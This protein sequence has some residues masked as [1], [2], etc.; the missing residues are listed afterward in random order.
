MTLPIVLGLSLPHWIIFILQDR[1]LPNVDFAAIMEFPPSSKTPMAISQTPN[2]PIQSL[3]KSHPLF[4]TKFNSS[5]HPPFFPFFFFFFTSHFLL[6]F[7]PP[8]T[9]V[10]PLS[11]FSHISN[12]QTTPSSNAPGRIPSSKRH[13]H[14]A[15]APGRVQSSVGP[16]L[17]ERKTAHQADVH[18]PLVRERCGG[19]GN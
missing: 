14:L 1:L 15:G 4:L 16:S 6:L 2:L 9:G 10:S 8:C 19:R 12:L 3:K 17:A 7:V 11:H 5:E 13:R 18:L